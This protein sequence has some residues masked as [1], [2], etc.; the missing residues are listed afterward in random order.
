MANTL[1]HQMLLPALAL[2]YPS[3]ELLMLSE[4]QGSYAFVLIDSQRKQAF[5]ARDPGG[6]KQSYSQQSA[7][8]SSD[9]LFALAEHLVCMVGD[10]S[11]G[12]E[13]LYFSVVHEDGATMFTNSLQDLPPWSHRRD[14][15]EIP[16]G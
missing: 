9:G 13:E 4:L 8:E 6:K 14:W 2:R 10:I 5:A 16:P 12:T 11:A 1:L 3:Q 15:H 7:Y